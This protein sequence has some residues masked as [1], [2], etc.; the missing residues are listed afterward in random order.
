MISFDVDSLDPKY[1]DSTGVM[2]PNGLHYSDVK[3]VISYAIQTKKLI[4]LDI[5][6]FNPELG[7]KDISV[8]TMRSVI[9]FLD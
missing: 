2:S 3:N 6:E 7:D 8:E 5:M 1:M 4:H 9:D